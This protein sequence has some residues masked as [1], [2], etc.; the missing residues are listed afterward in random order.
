M[1]AIA[2]V[3]RHADRLHA[4]PDRIALAGDSAGA[5]I[6]AQCAAVVTNPSY[7]AALGVVPT[8]EPAHLQAVVLCCG[9]FDPTLRGDGSDPAEALFLPFLDAV[10]WAYSGVRHWRLDATALAGLAVS[11][12]VGAAFPPTMLTVGNADPLA[13]QTH[14]MIDALEAHGATVE[15]LLYPADHETALEHEYQ[16]QLDL[17]DAQHA[18][19]RITA[20]LHDRTATPDPTPPSL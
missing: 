8:V 10:M 11:R 7:A 18:L 16:F 17:P 19:A 15:T 5:H 6:A 20:F 3:R 14:A 1:A 13:P 9:I 12:H 2:H 4:D